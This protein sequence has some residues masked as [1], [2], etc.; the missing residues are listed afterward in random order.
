MDKVSMWHI[1]LI[2]MKT[3]PELIANNR[4]WAADI[5]AAQPDFFTESAKGQQPEYLWIG[6]AD[7]RVPTNLVTG[8]QPGEIFVHR[9]IANL[10]VPGDNS[11][12]AVVQYAVDALKVKHVIIC[13]HYNCGGVLASMESQCPLGIVDGWIDNIRSVALEYQGELTPL[14]QATKFNRLCELNVIAQAKNLSRNQ[15]IQGAWGRGQK[16]A[17]HSWIYNLKDGLLKE[18]AEP[19]SQA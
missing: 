1:P 7:S 2:L 10:V 15:T 13:G 4:Q 5:Q 3:L 6:C 19:I 9:N 12:E 18:L 8:L 17:I 11:L 16:V 14:D